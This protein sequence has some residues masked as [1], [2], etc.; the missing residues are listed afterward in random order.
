M[1]VELETTNC[2]LCGSGNNTLL[3][4]AKDYRYGHPEVF[5]I[6]KCKDCGLIYLNPRPTAELLLE[7]YKKDY[8]P[9]EKMDNSKELKPSMMGLKKILGRFWYKI[10]GYYGIS[11]IKVEGRFLDI[12]CA[13]GDTLEAARNI[14][15]NVYGIELNPKSVEIC[16]TKGLDVQCGTVEDSGYP[17]DYFDII[18]M[19]Q[20]IEHLPFPK[21]SLKE[22]LR[23]LKP[24]GRLYIFCPNA[25]SYLSKLFGRFWHGWH[26]P[27]HFHAYTRETIT[28]LLTECGF[29]VTKLSAT[30]PY[31][32][33][34]VSLKSM[35]F[36]E[37]NNKPMKRHKVIDSLLFGAVSSLILR[38]F[39]FVL[40]G[41]GDCL[42]VVLIKE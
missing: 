22:I 23:I 2:D 31:H 29:K 36:G 28:K 14:G 41:K 40:S 35:L 21:K 15:A 42:K 34:S 6:V 13:K 32:F 38:I 30:T 10:S 19:S 18:W 16:K 27:F 20:V 24:C 26:I 9:N 12:G 1:S 11:E 33:F 7:Q 3:L 4:Q 25:G 8:T 5:D 17:D 39:D 37:P